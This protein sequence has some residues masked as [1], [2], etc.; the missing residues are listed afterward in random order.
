MSDDNASL[1]PVRG[2]ARIDV[3]DILRGIAI[4]GIF[5]MNIPFMGN[6]GI[7]GTT[8]VRRIG[9]SLADQRVWSFIEITWNGTQRG[10]LELLFGAGAMVLTARA[11]RPDGPVAV[12]DLFYRRNLWLL[13]FGLIDIFLIGWIGDILHIYALAALF[14]FPFRKLSARVLILLGLV[15]AV[16]SGFGV[17]GG[18]GYMEYRDR[19]ELMQTAEAARTK[20]EAK[21][22][23]S[24][25]ETKALAEWQKKVDRF[26]LSKPLDKEF[27]QF[28]EQ[29]VKAHRAGPLEFL[30]WT[31]GTWKFV[32]VD[33]HGSFFGVLE[34][35]GGMFIGMALWKLGVIQG[36]RSKGFYAALTIAAYAVGCGLR[37]YGVMELLPFTPAPKIYWI[38]DEFARLAVTLGHVGLVNLLVQTRVGK[39]ALSP[40]KAAGQTAFSLY[41]LTSIL[42]LWVIFAPW[43]LNLWAVYSWAGLAAIATVVIALLLILANIWTI[44]FLTGPLEW[45]WRSLAYWQLQPFRRHHGQATLPAEPGTEANPAL[46]T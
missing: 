40:F 18:G 5:Y 7:L 41:F 13:A 4:L 46:P 3:I 19:T 25:Q 2:K 27:K 45:A 14:I 22:P 32:F 21:K 17:I 36:L 35:I 38:I 9:W 1:A 24:G 23:L 26:D 44:W 16:G 11:M 12:A 28:H 31:W 42:G 10:L 6:S 29:E 33:D 34:A 43:G 39:K 30:P 15:Y 20:Q 37:G 8:D